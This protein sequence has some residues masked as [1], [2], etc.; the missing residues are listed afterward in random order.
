MTAFDDN[1]R[2]RKGL[3]RKTP[4]KRSNSM[5]PAT[6]KDGVSTPEK[7]TGVKSR[8][9]RKRGKAATTTNAYGR[10]MFKSL[11]FA[12]GEDDSQERRA[13]FDPPLTCKSSHYRSQGLLADEC[14]PEMLPAT[15]HETTSSKMGKGDQI[16][17]VN[18][19]KTFW[20]FV[21]RELRLW[22]RGV[23]QDY[24]VQSQRVWNFLRLVLVMEKFLLFGVSVCLDQ[25]LMVFTLLP[26][27]VTIGSFQ[28]LRDFRW[29]PEYLRDLSNMFLL[30]AAFLGLG[31]LNIPKLYHAVRAQSFMKLY[32]LYNMLSLFARLFYSFGE[33]LLDS[34]YGCCSNKRTTTLRFV[35]NLAVTAGFTI[36]HAAFMCLQ[37]V[38]LNVSINSN[39]QTLLVI[40][41][42]SQFVELKSSCFKKFGHKNLF[43]LAC[44]DVVERF[45]LF[46]FMTILTIQNTAAIGLGQAA[47]DW[48]IRASRVA[49]LL[50]VSE[51]FVDWLKHGFIIKFNMIDPGM[52]EVFRLIL[53][54]D[55]TKEARPS[56]AIPS[57][58]TTLRRFGFIPIPVAAVVIRATWDALAQASPTVRATVFIMTWLNLLAMKLF[59]RI[60]LLGHAC[61]HVF[62][63]ALQTMQPKAYRIPPENGHKTHASKSKA[64]N[65]GF[66]APQHTPI[67]L[68]VEK[69]QKSIQSLPM[70]PLRE[71]KEG[72]E[73]RQKQDDGPNQ[74]GGVG[75][76]SG[77]TLEKYTS[78]YPE[79]YRPLDDAT[80]LAG[81]SRYHLLESR[82]PV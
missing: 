66:S 48:L 12:I 62:A 28:F 36:L 50:Y 18:E 17:R 80:K 21:T 53:C 63:P 1:D 56:S 59:V 41:I 16:N 38:T 15:P 37:I 42:S 71:V 26:I 4:P 7:S 10:K 35:V 75:T 13:R 55:V 24:T 81:V 68:N 76:I 25:F 22:D 46:I 40:L 39:D 6:R 3:T 60:F 19:T 31:Y 23:V 49:F 5:G 77:E 8:R 2:Q 33:D 73:L 78:M 67:R 27:R 11:S 69:K 82:V 65:I 54:G 30:A 43:Q 74:N 45:E 58:R 51:C 64:E 34:L 32:V 61:K 70:A 52:Y 20:T 9:R 72:V 57:L 29:R 44:S 47:L 14:L 79:T